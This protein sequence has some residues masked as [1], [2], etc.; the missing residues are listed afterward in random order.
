[1]VEHLVYTNALTNTLTCFSHALS[2]SIAGKSTVEALS[3]VISNALKKLRQ[4]KK[5]C[6]KRTPSCIDRKKVLILR[7]LLFEFHANDDDSKPFQR[8]PRAGAG[9]S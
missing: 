1:V 9:Y 3:H 7:A 8:N 6:K 4:C 5:Q 2:C